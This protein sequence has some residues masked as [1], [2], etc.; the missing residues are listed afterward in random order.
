MYGGSFLGKT[1]VITIVQHLPLGLFKNDDEKQTIKLNKK[2]I[3]DNTKEEITS[4]EVPLEEKKEEEEAKIE[5]IHKTELEEEVEAK[6]VEIELQHEA[7]TEAEMEFQAETDGD[8]EIE[9]EAEVDTEGEGETETEV[10]V[11]LEV[12]SEEE[13]ESEAEVVYWTPNGKSYHMENTCRTLAR[14]KIIHS[15]TIEQS[16]KSSDCEHCRVV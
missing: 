10:K 11:D 7:D 2:D 5:L 14:S 8:V 13:P 1:T 4:L 3:I 9:V 15:G 6:E 16:G 12:E